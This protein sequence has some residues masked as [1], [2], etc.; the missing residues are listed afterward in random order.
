MLPTVIQM[1][2]KAPF[3]LYVASCEKGGGIYQYRISEQE[4][5]KLVGFT[6][7]DRPMYMTVANERM[8]V[9]LRAP[10]EN[11]ESGLISYD[12][13]AEG[14]LQNPTKI[15]STKGE[16]A[17][18]L[19]V[20]GKD[21]YAV[22]YISGSVIKMPD[23]LVTH[24]GKGV[25][26]ER[27]TSPHTHY[28]SPTPDGRYLCVTDL[29][30]DKIFVYG[31]DLTLLSAVDI[32]SGHGP[33]HLAFHK[34]GIHVFCAN[35]LAST[36]SVLEYENGTLKLVD[37]VSALPKDFHGNSTS[38]AI[39]CVGNTVYVSNRGHDSVTVL[40]FSSGH[41]VF[42]KTI[43][44]HGRSPRDFLIHDGLVIAA[45]ELS[46]KVTLISLEKEHTVGTLEVPSPVCVT[47]KPL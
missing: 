9:L 14:Q 37:T 29:G 21:V 2:H 5:P 20:D 13:D 33:R 40:D 16:V 15:L 46:H 10:F 34:D 43:S 30:T 32:P 17:C 4:E 27:Q 39:R 22:N 36:L 38:A 1:T 18:H 47:V 24:T 25:H 23:R 41:V 45:N 26:A 6:P 3:D 35:E 8:Y 7:M 42:K 28:V 12:I 44:T 19:T 11:A 31:K